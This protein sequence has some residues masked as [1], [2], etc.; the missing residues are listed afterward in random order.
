MR[1]D[2]CLPYIQRDV[3]K[4]KDAVKSNILVQDVHGFNKSDSLTRI[5]FTDKALFEG[6]T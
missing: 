3:K 5:P 2:L 1:N 6:I 4:N